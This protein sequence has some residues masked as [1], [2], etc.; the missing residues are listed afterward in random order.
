[1]SLRRGASNGAFSS[2]GSHRDRSEYLMKTE[3]LKTAEIGLTSRHPE[4]SRDMSGVIMEKSPAA[5]GMT[6]LQR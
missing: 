6:I 4:L 3:L 5:D 2:Y 1:M